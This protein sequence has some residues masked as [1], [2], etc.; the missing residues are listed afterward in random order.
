MAGKGGRTETSVATP[1]M[2]PHVVCAPAALQ[3][4]VA[5]DTAAEGTDVAD[6]ERLRSS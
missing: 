3:A 1:P 4:P 5:V 2:W 6:R